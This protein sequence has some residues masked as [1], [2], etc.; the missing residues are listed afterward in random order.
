MSNHSEEIGPL[1]YKQKYLKYKA[2]YLQLKAQLGGTDKCS[3]KGSTMCKLT[4]GCSWNEG[5]MGSN[6]YCFANDCD[7]YNKLTCGAVPGCAYSNNKCN[8][9]C[10]SQG[11]KTCS[12]VNGCSWVAPKRGNPYCR[13]TQQ[14]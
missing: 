11:Q 14:F 6:R 1:D 7:D 12:Q 9:N 13:R 4:I 3:S 5:Y 8:N 10:Q 2:K